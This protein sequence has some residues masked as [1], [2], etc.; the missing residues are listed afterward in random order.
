MEYTMNFDKVKAYLEKN[1]YVETATVKIGDWTET[2]MHNTQGNSTIIVS[3]IQT[4]D[5]RT[6]YYTF[7]ETEENGVIQT[8]INDCFPFEEYTPELGE[9]LNY[10][11]YLPAFCEMSA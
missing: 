10:V 2:T 6:L 7:T 11:Q 4:G 3:L 9:I 5:G 8:K 1:G